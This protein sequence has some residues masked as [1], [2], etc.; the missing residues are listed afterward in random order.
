MERMPCNDTRASSLRIWLHLEASL[1]GLWAD[2]QGLALGPSAAQPCPPSMRRSGGRSE[3]RS[4]QR[5]FPS[6]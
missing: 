5:E 1:S 3:R 6:C 4:E 2:R